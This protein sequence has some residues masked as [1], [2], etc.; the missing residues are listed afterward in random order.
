MFSSFDDFMRF[1]D[2]LY[3]QTQQTHSIARARLAE[4]LGQYL[5]RPVAL[6]QQRL[7]SRQAKHLARRR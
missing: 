5:G 2:W 6:P 4:L 1:S 3:A 7:R